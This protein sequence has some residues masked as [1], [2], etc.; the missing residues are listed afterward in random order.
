MQDLKFSKPEVKVESI[1]GDNTKAICTISPLERGYGITI[2]NSLRRVLLSSLPG[3][4]IVNVKIEGAE[5][6]FSTLEGVMEDVM[7]IVLNLKKVVLSV[8]STDPNFEKEIEIHQNGAGVVTASDIIHDSDIKIINPDQVIATVVE[9]GKLS[10][11]M[12]VRRGIGY[13]GSVKNKAYSNSV[14]VIAIDSIYTPINRVAYE[15]EKTRVNNDADYDKL[16][17]EVETNGAIKAHEALSLAA[18]MMI[19]YLSV[20]VDLDATTHD[21]SF[22]S[23]KVSET[24]THKLE[25]PIEELD[26]SVRSFNCLKRAGINTLAELTKKTEEEMM[27]VRNLGRK[28]LKEVKEKLEDLGLGFA[29]GYANGR[30]LD[31]ASDDDN[32]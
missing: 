25:K 22:M 27:R 6:E 15:V 9:G 1:S 31:V 28:S 26:L 20:I 29:A 4:A 17:M 32:E 30:K 12:T 21:I 23:E 7:S 2:G 19:D 5:H 11:Y 13:V 24:N 16:I 8:D 14:G 18:K 10:M 3:A